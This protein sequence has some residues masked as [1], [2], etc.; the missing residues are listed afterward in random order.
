MP[1]VKNIFIERMF[2]LKAKQELKWVEPVWASLLTKTLT[3]DPKQ[4]DN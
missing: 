4:G 3:Y 1:A 2:V